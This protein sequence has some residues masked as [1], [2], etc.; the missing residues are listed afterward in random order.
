MIISMRF[1]HTTV[2]EYA[3]FGR[4]PIL[5]SIKSIKLIFSIRFGNPSVHGTF[6]VCRHHNSSAC[7]MF[8]KNL[9]EPRLRRTS[10][11]LF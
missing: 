8:V 9:I 5:F 3:V 4:G 7:S 10:F 11:S 1:L 6:Q 2:S